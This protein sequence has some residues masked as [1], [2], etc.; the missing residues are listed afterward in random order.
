M[1][2]TQLSK[3]VNIYK[4][5]ETLSSPPLTNLNISNSINLTHDSCCFGNQDSYTPF[6]EQPLEDTSHLEKSVEVLQE[7]TLQ[8]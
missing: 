2:D 8:F 7:S 1:L 4:N 5:E 3:L 6:L